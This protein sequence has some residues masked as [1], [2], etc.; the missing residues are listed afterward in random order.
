MDESLLGTNAGDFDEEYVIRGTGRRKWTILRYNHLRKLTR[1]VDRNSIACTARQAGLE[2]KLFWQV[3]PVTL[4]QKVRDLYDELAEEYIVE[5][6]HG[7]LDAA[8][9][10]VLRLRLLQLTSGFTTAGDQI[11]DAKTTALR[12]YVENLSEQGEDV[13]VYCRFTA[14]V[15]SS[16]DLLAR[17]GYRTQVLDGRTRRR[18]RGHVVHSFQSSKRSPQA[19]VIQHQ[20][21]S[22]AIELTRAAEVVFLTL[23]DSWVDFWQCLNRL[24]GPNQHRPVRVTA[25]VARGTVDR[26]VLMNLRKK[27]DWHGDLMHDPHRFLRA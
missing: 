5:T 12:A 26:K 19:L 23:P 1:I 10:G 27:E 17:A 2:G 4:P 16:R 22:L 6:E 13:V 21:G 7:I 3:L 24:R 8:N 15:D 14:E 20:A 11:H 25:L 9:Q 18:D